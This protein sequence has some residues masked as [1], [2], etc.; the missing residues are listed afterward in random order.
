MAKKKQ[1]TPLQQA[2]KKEMKRLLSGA[3][4]YLQGKEKIVIPD[5]PKRVSKKLVEELKGLKPKAFLRDSDVVNSQGQK[6]SGTDTLRRASEE[7]KQARRYRKAVEQINAESEKYLQSNLQAEEDS[8]QQE[9]QRQQDQSY[10]YSYEDNYD[11][12]IPNGVQI[13][14]SNFRAT[15]AKYPTI[16][17]PLLLR[18]LES[19]I[20]ENGEENVAIMLQDGAE[21]GYI[22][23][24]EVAYSESELYNFMDA[25]LTYLPDQGELY[26]E[27]FMEA[28]ESIEDG[29]DLDYE[30]L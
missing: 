27:Q 10:N 21:N 8:R 13:I 28:M 14:I 23:T 7:R 11:D 6:K 24:Y 1:L 30:G 19:L 17:Q 16:A 9:E 5:M 20:Q 26:R 2:Y 25:M 29:Y 4:R 12:Y 15:I 18:W 22:I 3:K